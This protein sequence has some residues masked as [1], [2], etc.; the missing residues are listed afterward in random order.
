[1]RNS[2]VRLLACVPVVSLSLAF[3]AGCNS[4]VAECNKLIEVLNAQ[5]TKLDPKGSD[6]SAFTNLATE[7]EGAAKTV[8]EVDVKTPEIVQFRD[9][10]KKNLMDL[11]SAARDAGAA[12]QSQ[13]I[14][15]I[16]GV[17]TKLGDISKQNA[18]LV[19]DVNNF[20]Q[21]K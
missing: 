1:M 17:T 5:A 11:G 12:M 15:K 20:C 14:A 3:A 2:V 6:P 4:K 21:G 13:D 19:T 9:A 8:S 18:K 16:T 7:A 10:M